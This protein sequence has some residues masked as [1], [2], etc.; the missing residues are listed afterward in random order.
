MYVSKSHSFP[1]SN[2]LFGVFRS[3]AQGRI[4]FVLFLLLSAQF[5]FL[6]KT[7]SKSSERPIRAPPR[8]T[9]VSP[10]FPLKR[11]QCLVEH[12]PFPTS[13]AGMSATSFINSPFLQAI[14]VVMLHVQKVPQ[15]Y[16]HL[17]PATLQ[18]RCNI[19]CACHSICSFIPTDP[20]MP[21]AEDPQKSL[22]PKTLHG[23]VPIGAAHPR[24]HL[25]QDVHWVCEN[26]GM[27]NLWV[28][29]GG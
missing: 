13:E 28:T 29:L 9:A 10:R 1:S 25:L 23:C 15:A 26:D 3:S 16:E 7:A 17:C 12:R 14:D 11:Y 27:C 24:L 4:L 20:G 6:L 21:R 19:C 18:T 5:Q 22:Q 2:L 8:L